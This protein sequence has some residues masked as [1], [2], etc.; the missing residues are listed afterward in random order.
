[1]ALWVILL[2]ILGTLLASAISAIFGLAGGTIL[3]AI[4][5]WIMDS[6][7][8]VA[9]HSNIQMVSNLSRFV[10]YFRATQW[11]VVGWF[12]LLA[13]PGAYLGGLVYK[14]INANFLELL[15]GIFILATVFLPEKFNKMPTSNIMF[16]ILGFLSNFLGMI[17]AVTGPFISSFFVL[18]NLGKEKVIATKAVCQGL[19]Q[20][21]KVIVFATSVGF[22][23]G[24]YKELLI[25]L[26]LASILGTFLGKIVMKKMSEQQFNQI[27]SVL[28]AVIA[29]IMI[30]KG[31]FNLLEG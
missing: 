14:E 8:A 17:V 15:V 19:T 10:A 16:I 23:F 5:T 22:D 30:I 20:V 31:I 3:F 21:V 18:N 26:C 7:S 2:L 24:N 13:V 4:L 1:M 9:I 12:L 25:V 6:K 11:R 28:L 27:N 29:S